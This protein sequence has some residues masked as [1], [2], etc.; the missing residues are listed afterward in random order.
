MFK[1]FLLSND[2]GD[3]KTG[4][5]RRLWS[6]MEALLL[7]L[8]LVSGTSVAR[9]QVVTADVIGTVT[10]VSG[11]VIPDASIAIENTGTHERRTS[12]SAA[13]G[14][15][16]FNALQPG[17]YVLT[18]T[19][20]GFRTFQAKSVNVVGGD[21]VR[22]D[23][24]LQPGS[25]SEEVTVTSEVSA[26]QTD[27]T[28]VGTTVTGR[29]VQDIPINGR[30][31]MAIVQVAAGVNA[32]SPNS[33][34]AGGRVDDRRPTSALSA[35]GQPESANN[36]LVDGMDNNG[37]WNSSV[38]LRP[39]V[40]A[41]EQVRTDVN[42]YTAEVGRTSGAAINIITK[43]GTNNF[44][45]SLFEFFRNDITDARNF[46]ATS[47]VLANKPE[48]RQN[49]FGGSIGGPIVRD[50]TFFFADFEEFNRID[51]SNSVYLTSVPT[52]YEHQ[53]PGDL[54]DIGGTVTPTAS[55]NPTTLGYF[56]LYPLPNQTGTVSANGI[57]QNNFLYNPALRQTIYL[58]DIRVDQ[59]F[60]S[61]NS[62]FSRYSQNSTTTFIPA[63]F[64]QVAP[65]GAIAAGTNSAPAPGNSQQDTRNAQLG[66]THIFTP[67]LISETKIS[68]T[69]FSLFFTTP[70]Y[71]T[72]FNDSAPYLIP[73]ANECIYC[74]GLAAIAITGAYSNLGD[75]TQSPAVRSDNNYQILSNLTWNHG[76]HTVKGG[77][78]VIQRNLSTVQQY[79]KA[80][81]TFN[82][83]TPQ[84]ALAN[85]FAGT[86]F[87]FQ[88]TI[89]LTTP[90]YRSYEPA[91]FIQDDWHA[92]PK[93]TFNIGLRYEIFTPASEKDGKLTDFD[94]STL[95][96]VNN[97]TGGVQTSYVDV[98]P[99]F[100]FAYT[101]HQGMVVRGGFGM[102]HYADDYGA[103]LQL[104]NPSNGYQTGT[105]NFT[106]PISAG[107][108]AATA[109]S[110]A[111]SA[112]FGAIAAKPT[113]FRH[114]YI[115][116]YN[117]LV[118]QEALGNVF[119]L[120]YVGSVSRHQLEQVPNAD[121]PLP[122]GPSAP[123]TPAPAAPYATTLPN[124]NTI[125][126][127]GDGGSG[128]YN[129]L[130]AS[131]ERRLAKGFSA[132]FN[133]TLAHGLDD[134]QNAN[135]QEAGYGLIPSKIG[136]YDYGNSFI[137]V[138]HRFAGTFTYSL[139]FGTK[140]SLAHRLLTG[141]YQIN[142]LGFW[143]TGTPVSITSSYT[144]NGRAQ[145][146]ISNTVTADRPNRGPGDP[147]L[148]AGGT[149]ASGIAFL[150][151]AAF[152]RQPLGTA[153][154]IGR[155]QFY[156][157]HTRRGDLSVFKTVPLHEAVSAQF[158]VECFNI[159]NTPNFA[160]PNTVIA[161]YGTAADANGNFEA[162][163]A[164]NFGTI[165]ST[166]PGYSNRQFQFALRV[167]F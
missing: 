88:R 105:L 36:Q 82:A 57:P 77:I 42:T 103:S 49:Q 129:S 160:Q 13:D 155:N 64:P 99:R 19:T 153:G 52:V 33:L 140:G 131:V 86:P 95:T 58:G 48:L 61:N 12:T 74:S 139:P 66:Y 96:M 23:T 71:G 148:H 141:G 154:N 101:P 27:S 142:G 147:Y 32:G 149:A 56:G 116:Q 55:I 59:H 114:T 130:Q 89:T 159:T 94:L 79:D 98:S 69:Y 15:Y 29:A 164:S 150:N 137:D 84:L 65:T 9:A 163:A 107:I 73:Q 112:L 1:I 125:A 78:S 151:P 16:A 46:F 40:E 85:F 166:A 91:F 53:H 60:N 110:T 11:A 128:S 120:G 17:S 161:S 121:L 35:N 68:Y 132:N 117:L 80:A 127:W 111:T 18:V 87:R 31:Y 44:H 126:Y 102:S 70:N 24:P 4:G 118:Q 62:L 72:N 47:S 92:T 6:A 113:N 30:N 22:I 119:T 165:T 5:L 37:R 167:L 14:A 109:T 124:V 25:T 145:I 97:N 83:N 8:I 10:Y 81:F 134:V 133:Y 146:N 143:Q 144:Q 39:S 41:I 2:A 122:A 3:W 7:T 158:R 43:S 104:A 54:S 100:G 156:G 152:V 93:L 106:T 51:G 90:H 50:K 38:E 45:G 63:L 75:Q 34:A 136:T 123:G 67:N 162:T 115:E 20:Q 76:Q 26:L 157:P 108:P 28:N 135:D 21:R 138:R